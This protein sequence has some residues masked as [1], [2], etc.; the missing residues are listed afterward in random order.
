M[1][2][3]T[4]THIHTHTHTHTHTLQKLAL[5]GITAALSSLLLTFDLHLF[6]LPSRRLSVLPLSLIGLTFAPVCLI[7]AF[8][9]S[10]GVSSLFFCPTIWLLETNCCCYGDCVSS[11]HLSSV[12]AT[13]TCPVQC[14]S[15]NYGKPWGHTMFLS[16]KSLRNIWI[17]LVH[18]DPMF[19]SSIR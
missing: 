1:N 16:L 6:I 17:S 12:N 9:L 4:H 15:S 5:A 7:L 2:K 14:K 10:S 3:D 18:T 19:L 8:S 13:H 11:K